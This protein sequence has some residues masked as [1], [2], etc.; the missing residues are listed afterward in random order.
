MEYSHGTKFFH[1]LVGGYTI[2][3]NVNH[4]DGMIRVGL[5]FAHPRDTYNHKIARKISYGRMM[6]DSSEHHH[7]I[8]KNRLLMTLEKEDDGNLRHMDI[9][10]GIDEHIHLGAWSPVPWIVYQNR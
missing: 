6:D 9:V 4:D 5:A 10:N 7:D 1:N 2:C 8:H 3:Y